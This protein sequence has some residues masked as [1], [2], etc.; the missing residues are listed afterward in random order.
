MVPE[1]FILLVLCSG[2]GQ[3]GR[4]SKDKDLGSCFSD[5]FRS[6]DSEMVESTMKKLA[7][8]EY[9]RMIVESVPCVYDSVLPSNFAFPSVAIYL[10][11][12]IIQ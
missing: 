4:P 11:F 8:E 9:N 10:E 2:V 6:C 7:E 3:L 1:D 12:M 5:Y